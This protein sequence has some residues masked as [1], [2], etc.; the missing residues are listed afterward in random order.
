MDVDMFV[1]R[2]RMSFQMIVLCIYVL[3]PDLPRVLNMPVRVYLPK[4]MDG[5]I[6]CPVEANPPVTIFSWSKND[7]V[8]DFSHTTRLKVSKD[9]TLVFKSVIASD[10]GWYT[11]TPFSPL[12]A[13]K[14]SS[15]VQIIV[16][17]E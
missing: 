16:R 3:V 13:G 8:I 7:K 10:E 6:L 5:R 2:I 11:C 15:I 12:G 14:M 4:G 1:V 17:G 9:G